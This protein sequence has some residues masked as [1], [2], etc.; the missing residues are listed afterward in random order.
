MECMVK[1]YGMAETRDTE[2]T[3]KDVNT[4]QEGPDRG[5]VMW[6]KRRMYY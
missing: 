5:G 3:Q 4:G 2:Q 6:P 1:R